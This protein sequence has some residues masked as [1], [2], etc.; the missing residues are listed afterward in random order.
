[1]DKKEESKM[2]K[3]FLDL[4][5]KYERS[6][7]QIAA[8]D[9]YKRFQP[10]KA[11]RIYLSV[12]R[13]AEKKGLDFIAAE[14]YEASGKIRK[15]R[16]IW[17]NLGKELGKQRLSTLAADASEKSKPE[18]PKY[19]KTRKFTFAATRLAREGKFAEAQKEWIGAAKY[20]ERIGDFKSAALFY[21]NGGDIKNAKRVWNK[22]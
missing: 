20:R 4:A 17:K 13:N 2:K 5:K 6:G 14:A 15:A 3:Y 19:E 11:K 8:A 21:F 10:A 16:S 1:M 9:I 12:A 22:S 7:F 18:N